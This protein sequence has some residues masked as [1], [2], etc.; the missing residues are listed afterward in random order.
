MFGLSL[1]KSSITSGVSLY[2]SIS[3]TFDLTNLLV[4]CVTLAFKLSNSVSASSML[5]LSTG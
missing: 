4:G 3:L 2:S 1:G 5:S